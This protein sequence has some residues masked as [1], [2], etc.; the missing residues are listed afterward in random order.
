MAIEAQPVDEFE[1]EIGLARRGNAGVQQT[2]DVRLR[3]PGGQPI[4]VDDP[5]RL[6]AIG[7]FGETAFE[8]KLD[9]ARIQVHKVGDDV[10]MRGELVQAPPR[11][12]DTVGA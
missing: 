3:Q 7:Q 6:E 10:R 4:A 9:G 8:Y 1:D 11:L 2:G 12:D 5:G